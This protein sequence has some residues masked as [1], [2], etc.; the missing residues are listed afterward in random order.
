VLS[1]ATRLTSFQYPLPVT[2]A[3]AQ[4]RAAFEVVVRLAQ[5]QPL[6]RI[7]WIG[8]PRLV[9]A[10]LGLRYWAFDTV[11]EMPLLPYI[12]LAHVAIER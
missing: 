10:R 11:G 2:A 6:P 8:L 4:T 3:P 9:S 12:V 7:A 5:H 1:D